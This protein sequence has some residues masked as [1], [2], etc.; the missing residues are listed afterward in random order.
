MCMCVCVIHTH[1][2][3]FI[4]III[5]KNWCVANDTGRSRS[6]RFSLRGLGEHV[7]WTHLVFE[8][9]TRREVSSREKELLAKV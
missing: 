8:I 2:Y 5:S 4:Y 6:D 3:I 7:I 1:T 9:S